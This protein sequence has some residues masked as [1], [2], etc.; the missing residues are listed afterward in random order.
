[1]TDLMTFYVYGLAETLAL[2][3]LCTALLGAA[4]KWP[5][6]LP[7]TVLYFAGVLAARGLPLHFGAHTVLAVIIL[8]LLVSALFSISVG[9]TV[10]AASISVV[11]LIVFELAGMT[12][13]RSLT[14]VDQDPGL[15]LLG[16]LPV[17]A[18][19]LAAALLVRRRKLTL[20]PGRA[21][22]GDR[23]A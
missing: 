21:A 7:V 4:W 13:V 18:L 20:F 3:L 16:R 1:M 9:R 19:L 12:I 14:E 10:V 17:V 11:L 2:V 15:W 23:G 8:A 6:L 5:R 22:G